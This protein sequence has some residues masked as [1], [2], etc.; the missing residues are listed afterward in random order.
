LVYMKRKELPKAVEYFKKSADTKPAFPDPHLNLGVAYQDMGL[1]EEAEVQYLTAMSLAPLNLHIRN[2]LGSL[3]LEES[4]VQE[5]EGQFAKSASIAPN[6]VAYDALGQIL[7]RRRA[8]TAAEA[9]FRRSISLNPGDVH[10]REEL[11]ELYRAAGQTAKAMEQYQAILKTNPQNASALE[12][13][14]KLR[15]SPSSGAHAPKQ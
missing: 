2:R 3:Y 6:V 11:A 12:G 13:L 4:R 15:E 8:Y 5:A 1:K 9:M 14:Q 7:L 10:A